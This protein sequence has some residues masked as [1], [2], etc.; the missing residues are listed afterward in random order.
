M[1]LNSSF[2][3]AQDET[4]NIEDIKLEA[5]ANMKYKKEMNIDKETDE[6][7]LSSD[8]IVDSKKSNSESVSGELVQY[9]ELSGKKNYKITCVLNDDVREIVSI[10]LNDGSVGVAYKKFGEIKT[11]AQSNSGYA[12]QVADKIHNNLANGQYPYTCNKE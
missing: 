12:D 4:E 3:Y 5:P 8:E 10:T 6:I 1:F 11:M 2:L 7:K 9:G